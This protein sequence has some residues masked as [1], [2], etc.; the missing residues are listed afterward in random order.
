[1]PGVR[2][3]IIVDGGS[4]DDTRRIAEECAARLIP[5]TPG[6]GLQMDAGARAAKGDVLWF[7]HADTL[8]PPGA[9]EAILHTLEDPGIVGGGFC[10]EFSGK[11]RAARFFTAAYPW[12]RRLGFLYGDA[13]LFVRASTYQEIGGFRPF[14][15]FEDLNL[16]RRM[17]RQGRVVCLPG[18]VLTSSRRFEG[19]GGARILVQWTVLHLLYAAG[20]SPHVLGRLYRPIRDPQATV[21]GVVR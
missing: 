6:R 1:M 2:E 3:I 19:R 11:S 8:P 13:A 20:V 15:V 5:A 17:R 10:V 7:L 21:K 16:V 4:T 9:A 12:M 18:P 14:P